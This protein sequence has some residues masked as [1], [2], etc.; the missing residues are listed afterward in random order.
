MQKDIQ[1]QK[2]RLKIDIR[3]VLFRYF[4]NALAGIVFEVRYIGNNAKK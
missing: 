2:H 4:Q 1:I 3:K